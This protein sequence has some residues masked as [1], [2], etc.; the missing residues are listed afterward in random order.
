M[1]NQFVK[2]NYF[3]CVWLFQ[4]ATCFNPA[5]GSSSGLYINE[6]LKSCACWD[7]FMLTSCL[8]L[9]VW[10]DFPK[11]NN[12]RVNRNSKWIYKPKDSSGPHYKTSQR[13]RPPQAHTDTSSPHNQVKK[14]II[15]GQSKVYT[16]ISPH[17]SELYTTNIL[18]PYRDHT[19]R[20]AS[21]TLRG[22]SEATVPAGSTPQCQFDKHQKAS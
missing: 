9:Q 22:E 19:W 2:H 4:W 7:P 8:V 15:S 10:A 6:S 21:H 18:L 5:C 13:K 16:Q 20:K 1:K 3:Y 12:A 17:F 11:N 14:C